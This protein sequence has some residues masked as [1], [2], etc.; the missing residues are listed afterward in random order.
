MAE[1][2]GSD[3][4]IAMQK[5]L[6]RRRDVIDNCPWL[7]SGG[8]ILVYVDPDSITWPGVRILA[9]ED[10]FLALTVLDR[11]R[12]EFEVARGLGADWHLD[13]WDAFLGESGEVLKASATVAKA[14]P[15]PDGWQ[16]ETT[17]NPDADE[18]DE[19][20]QLNLATG[21]SPNPAVGG[22]GAAL[23]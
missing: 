1:Y 23:R 18:I 3:A 13:F 6:R 14:T 22:A 21:V 16:L 20:Q 4:A 17:L 11:E 15:L 19:V 5:R 9:E 2:V 7:A 8:R 10:G 12:M